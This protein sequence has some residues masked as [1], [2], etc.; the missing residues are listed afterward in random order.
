[1]KD[2]N[3]EVEN[4]VSIYQKR[5]N[6]KD[7]YNPLNPFEIMSF[8]EKERTLI[9]WINYSG[10]K[11]IESKS[12]LEI[13]CGNGSNLLEF[14]KL[15]F[16]PENLTGNELQ[17]ERLLEAEKKLP[18]VTNLVEGNALDL[19][20]PDESFDIVFQSLVFSS[21][22]NKEFQKKLAAKMWDFIK[23]GGGILWYDFIYN[24]PW[25]KDV[26]GIPVRR[27]KELFQSRKIKIWKL[28]LI[29]PLGRALV[30]IHPGLYTLFNFFYFTRTHV[31]CW[32]PKLP[33][34]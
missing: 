9:R 11:H 1:M 29:P 17:N 14:I 7:L 15:G 25:N 12:L 18:S 21:I 24:N 33:T 20:L 3:K 34:Q 31:L 16:S 13:G 27:V 22:L 26:V 23:P 8:Q 6:L 19:H 32:I 10:L 4:L 2:F 28:T 30:K 5:K